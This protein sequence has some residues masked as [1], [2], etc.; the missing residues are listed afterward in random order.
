MFVKNENTAL[1]RLPLSTQSFDIIRERNFIYVDKTEYIEKMLLQFRIV[2]LSRPRRF[3]KSLMLS[4]IHALFEGKKDLFEGL[5]IYDKWDWKQTNPVIKID[6]TALP[7]DTPESMKI[8]LVNY[9]HELAQKDGIT[10]ISNSSDGCFRELITNLHKKYDRKVV[11]L[12]DE[13]DKP[14]TD[15]LS[16]E[17]LENFIK[18]THDFY[19]VMKGTD[20]HIEFVFLTGVSKMSGLSVFSALNNI[21]DI[22]LLP[23]F[24]GICGY[25]KDELSSYFAE[26][27][28]DT[29]LQLDITKDELLSEIKQWYDGY[30]WDGK[31]KIYNP[32][33]IIN[34]FSSKE[35]LNFWFDTAT[36]TLLL[37]IIKN[38]KEPAI[39]EL[40]ISTSKNILNNGYDPN[41][42]DE[43]ILLYQTGY[44]TIDKITDLKRYILD[45]PNSEV[46]HAFFNRLYAYYGSNTLQAVNEIRNRIEDN[47]RNNN[48]ELLTNA[49]K[50]LVDLP[51]QIKADKEANLHALLHIGL[52]GIGFDINSEISTEEGR[53][54]AVWRLPYLTVITEIKRSDEKS[55]DTLLDDAIS[56]IHKRKYYEKYLGKITLLAVVFGKDGEVKC[57][58]EQMER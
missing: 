31:T 50:K 48:P 51:Y 17:N 22:S 29:S 35:F 52:F 6:W 4:T 49:F 56:Q 20:E 38:K 47:I 58:M 24:A 14:V 40:P 12:I 21:K 15:A 16:N 9:L 34:F 39:L 19:Q 43:T 7:S 2:F 37:E 26:H 53:I 1:Q 55:A 11:V 41:D 25:T 28:E 32:Y 54:D 8:G 45:F 13:Y 42:L 10:L 27:L 23:E 18:I 30:T 3:G 36:P 44:L 33:S 46:K 57:K 5:Y